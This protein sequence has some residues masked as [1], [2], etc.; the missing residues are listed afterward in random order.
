[1]GL[2]AAAAFLD[3]PNWKCAMLE[4]RSKQEEKLLHLLSVGR[5]HASQLTIHIRIRNR[6]INIVVI[7]NL[8][9]PRPGSG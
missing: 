9:V 4:Y 1:M 5:L 3:F 8:R 7:Q 6:S 2:P